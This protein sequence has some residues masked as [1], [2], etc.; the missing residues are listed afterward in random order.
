MSR[1]GSDFGQYDDDDAKPR[2]RRNKDGYLRREDLLYEFDCPECNANNPYDDGFA[3][4]A[5]IACHYCGLEF[6][7]TFLEGKRLKFKQI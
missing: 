5:E 1:D 3:D 2:L 4:Q 6:R 7:V